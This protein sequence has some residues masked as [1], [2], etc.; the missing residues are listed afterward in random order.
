MIF[1]IEKEKELEKIVRYILKN[2]REQRIF[3]LSGD[4]GTG[5]TSFVKAFCQYLNSKDDVNSPTFTILNQYQTDLGTVHHMD[6]YR[7]KE[8]ND[9]IETGIYEIMDSGDYCF[10]EW[11]EL[12]REYMVL[13]A[14]E[15]KISIT[16]E[17]K[18]KI[19]IS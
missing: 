17:S 6:L 1:E 4:L 13:D 3:F 12:L 14:I 9:L 19:V 15:I 2:H 11:P 7:L 18:R 8:P 10:V 5:K 16:S